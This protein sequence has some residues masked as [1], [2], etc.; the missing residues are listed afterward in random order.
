MIKLTVAVVGLAAQVESGRAVQAYLDELSF[1]RLPPTG[2]K[3]NM[4]LG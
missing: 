4:R 3:R 1:G 2:Q